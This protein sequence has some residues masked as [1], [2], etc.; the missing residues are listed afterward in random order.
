MVAPRAAGSPTRGRP[1]GRGRA[2]R[3]PA[4]FAKMSTPKPSAS[5]L[6][7]L[8]ARSDAVRGQGD[9]ARRPVEEALQET[10]RRLWRAFKWLDEAVAHL[11]V[12][13][14]AAVRDEESASRLTFVSSTRPTLPRAR[15]RPTLRLCFGAMPI[16]RKEQKTASSSLRVLFQ[17]STRYAWCRW[18]HFGIVLIC[19]TSHSWIRSVNTYCLLP[20]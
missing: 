13:K 1:Y 19:F 2:D 17:N 3:Q 7:T 20:P 10:D 18:L 12:I 9:A 6:E 15:R 4:T 11:E 8:R 5:L 16:E 14:P